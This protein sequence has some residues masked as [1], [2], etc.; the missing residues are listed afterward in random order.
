MCLPSIEVA[1]RI[2]PPGPHP[3]LLFAIDSTRHQF[4]AAYPT[5][6][7]A[8]QHLPTPSSPW[9]CDSDGPWLHKDHIHVLESLRTDVLQE[10]HDAA[11]AGHPGTSRTLELV[12]RNYWF[13]GI[14]AFVKDYVNSCYA[15]Q[16]P[17]RHPRHGELASLPVPTSPWNG[18]PCG[19]ITDLPVSNGKDSIIASCLPIE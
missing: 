16:K 7:V 18:L 13:P 9:S 11:L 3:S 15:C 5:D 10:H 19:F 6:P 17:T 8:Q 14:N 12:T 1:G 4:L 2:I